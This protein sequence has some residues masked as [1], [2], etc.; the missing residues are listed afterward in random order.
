MQS[1]AVIVVVA[2][3]WKHATE[4]EADCVCADNPHEHDAGHFEF[5]QFQGSEHEG[6]QETKNKG[7]GNVL[8][9]PPPLRF[10][11][12]CSRALKPSSQNRLSSLSRC[13]RPCRKS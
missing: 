11:P 8:A 3:V 9:L 6:D 13:L 5:G 1:L 10:N 7:S 4:G 2:I 12:D